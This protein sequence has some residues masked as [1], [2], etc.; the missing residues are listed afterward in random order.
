MWRSASV[1]CRRVLDGQPTPLS[2]VRPAPDGCPGGDR[3]VREGRPLPGPE[4]AGRLVSPGAVG[5]HPVWPLCRDGLA[6]GAG[7][8]APDRRGGRGGQ[9]LM[10]ICEVRVEVGRTVNDGNY[11]SERISVGLV[12]TSS[13]DER[14]APLVEGLTRL[15]RELV[16]EQLRQSSS[17]GVRSAIKHEDMASKRMAPESDVMGAPA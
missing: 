1:G 15:C 13:A 16:L 8:G 9:R 17:P 14:T 4:P 5:G 7:R 2:A 12:A 11:G 6:N 10:D 3:L